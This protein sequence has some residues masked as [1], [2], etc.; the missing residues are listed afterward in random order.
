M[1][2]R[3][4]WLLMLIL[5][6]PDSFGQRDET[7]PSTRTPQ[8]K[9]KRH[10]PPPKD[11]KI[12]DKRGKEP[13]REEP[14]RRERIS[15]PGRTP[16]LAPP[17]NAFAT[18]AREIGSLRPDIDNAALKCDE[19]VVRATL[20]EIQK[21]YVE[22]GLTKENAQTAALAAW[23]EVRLASPLQSDKCLVSSSYTAFALSLGTI[24]F[25][26]NPRYANIAV[27]GK[28]YSVQTEYSKLFQADV[29]RRVRYSKPGY[30]PVEI[31]CT[32]VERATI[33]CY[34]ELKPKP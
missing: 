6:A 18:T 31:E 32:A 27:D 28:D 8:P 4:L 29:K 23:K 2:V 3:F 12:F 14:R 20:P 15:A 11:P 30:E 19:D 22:D 24:N 33:D 10:K 26:S 1:K 17:Q 5:L 13:G 34:A 9:G 25:K 21:V 7:S 16:Q